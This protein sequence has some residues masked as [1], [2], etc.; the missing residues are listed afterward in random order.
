MIRWWTHILLLMLFWPLGAE[1]VTPRVST[2][3][4]PASVRAGEAIPVSVDIHWTGTPQDL[5][6]T[7][8]DLGSAPGVEIGAI[9]HAKRS[10]GDE[11]THT[12]TTQVTLTVPGTQVLGPLVVHYRDADQTELNLEVPGTLSVEVLP[13]QGLGS[14]ALLLG[15]LAALGAGALAWRSWRRRPSPPPPSPSRPLADERLS[16]CRAYVASGDGAA[17]IDELIALKAMLPPEEDTLPPRETLENEAMKARYGGT[18][19]DFHQI[20]RWTRAAQVA[21]RAAGLIGQAPQED[22]GDR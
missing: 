10:R 8:V 18:P 4:L 7:S 15:I 3:P 11:V 13:A 2:G 12:V 14:R 22:G 21:A 6:I 20:E 5:Q 19:P 9:T 16:S 17:A 1:A